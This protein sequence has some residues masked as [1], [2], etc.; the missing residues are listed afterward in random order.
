MVPPFG[1]DLYSGVRTN[2]RLDP[3]RLS[4]FMYAVSQATKPRLDHDGIAADRNNHVSATGSISWCAS[5]GRSA[6]TIGL[7][8]P[9][10]SM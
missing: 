8:G 7:K 2:G 10:H 5:S 6:I 3:M 9:P 1:L 4:A